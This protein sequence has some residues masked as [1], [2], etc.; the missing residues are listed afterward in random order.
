M[1]VSE[2]K[3]RFSYQV[4]PMAPSRRKTGS[5]GMAKGELRLGD[6]VLA[7]VK[8]FPAWPAKVRLLLSLSPS[9]LV[10]MASSVHDYGFVLVLH[11][12][13]STCLAL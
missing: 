11:I 1:F 12:L 7:K 2:L 3:I 4:S 6:L 10:F 5:K 9:M 8:G 13:L